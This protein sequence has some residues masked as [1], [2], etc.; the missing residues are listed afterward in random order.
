[1]FEEPSEDTAVFTV[2]LP[3]EATVFVV[4]EPVD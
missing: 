3:H 4:A 2:A 1:V